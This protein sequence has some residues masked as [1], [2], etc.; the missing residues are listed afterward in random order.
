M[1]LRHY[2]GFSTGDP[3]LD[4]IKT[5][6]LLKAVSV[7]DWDI[8]TDYADIHNVRIVVHD[9]MALAN[10]SSIGDQLSVYVPR[11]R[12]MYGAE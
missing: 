9:E 7:C 2:V 11:S 6:V 4:D 12:R 5:H 10:V 1:T 3:V 8:M